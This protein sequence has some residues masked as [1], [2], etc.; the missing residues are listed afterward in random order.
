MKKPLNTISFFLIVAGVA[1]A[2]YGSTVHQF[3][4]TQVPRDTPMIIAEVVE[5]PAEIP[6]GNPKPNPM[7][8][9][10]IEKVPLAREDEAWVNLTFEEMDLLEQIAY[11][12][13]R[14]EG[15]KGMALVM[16][17]VLNRSLR[18]N[19]SITEVIFAQGQFYTAGMTP[20]VS[21]ECHE[22]LGMVIDGWDESEG[23]CYFQK[24]GYSPWG[25]VELFK[26][27]NHYFSK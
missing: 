18:D 15:S 4:N 12:E 16:R 22:A 7:D 23:A 26:Y 13:A 3:Q 20:N 8:R 17:V 19:Q 25:T 6:Q 10:D 14:G 11:A 24:Y 5:E 9:P 27:G 1:A 21:D 2:S